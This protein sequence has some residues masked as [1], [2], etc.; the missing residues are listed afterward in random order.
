MNAITLNNHKNLF[1]GVRALKNVDLEIPAGD[2]F[3]FRNKR[4]GENHIDWHFNKSCNKN[5]R[6]GKNFDYDLDTDLN[7]PSF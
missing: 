1:D 2:F 4:S 6:S 5:V 3:A 7:R